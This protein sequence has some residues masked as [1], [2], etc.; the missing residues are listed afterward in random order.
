[1]ST[2]YFHFWR[3]EFWVSCIFHHSR[4]LGDM[5]SMSM[6]RPM[7][8]TQSMVEAARRAEFDYYQRGRKLPTGAFVPTPGAVIRAMLEA[9]MAE[10]PEPDTQAASSQDTPLIVTARK[11]RPRR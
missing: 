4:R 10:L 5:V 9:A 11:P 3:R 2:G 7:R 1:M 8:V 6:E